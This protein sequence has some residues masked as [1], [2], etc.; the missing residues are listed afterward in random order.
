MMLRQKFSSA[1]LPAQ[2]VMYPGSKNRGLQPEV[3]GETY[4]AERQVI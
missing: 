3:M 4:Y 2:I 1:M